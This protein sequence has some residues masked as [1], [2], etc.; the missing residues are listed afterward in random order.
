MALGSKKIKTIIINFFRGITPS[1]F[2][3]VIALLGFHYCGSVN[4]GEFVGL[5]LILFFFNFLA[6]WGNKEYLIRDFSQTPSRISKNYFSSLITRS[7]F[8]VLTAILFAIYSYET[9]ILGVGLIL[10]RFIYLSFESLVIYHQKFGIQLLSECMSFIIICGGILLSETFSI[11]YFISLYIAAFLVKIIMMFAF[12]R[13]NVSDKKIEFNK[14]HLILG[15]PFFLISLSGWL[16]YKVDLYIVEFSLLPADL[17]AYQVLVGAYIL[18][19]TIP[20]LII[21]PFTKHIYRV[22]KSLLIKVKRGLKLVAI[23][24]SLMGSLFVYFFLENFTKITYPIEVYVIITISIV[25]IYFYLIDILLMYKKHQ[26][27]TIMLISFIGAFINFTVTL[28]GIQ[29]YGILG[30][31][32]GTCMAKIVMLAIPFYSKKEES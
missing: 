2:N 23:P 28:V 30:A 26:E 7:V 22:N 21:Q 8:L 17:S 10:V 11:N 12:V 4:W 3:F 6:N 31:V 1:I 27:K 29:Y 14:S 16:H 15:L 32:I 24:I 20:V 9:A 13:S 5:M 25:P 18:V 19:E